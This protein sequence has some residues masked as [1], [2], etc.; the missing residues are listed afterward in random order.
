MNLQLECPIVF[1]DLETTGT[2]V[3]KDRIVELFAKK[4]HPQGQ[5]EEY[6]Q[7]INP[8]M[9]I[10][11]GASKVHGITN[12]K[13]AFEPY[14]ED[15]APAIAEFF[16]G[17]DVGGYNILRF[18]VPILIEEFYRSNLENP[19]ENANFVDSMAIFHKMVPRSLAGALKYYRNKDLV[20]A[21]SAKGDVLA[22]I[23][24]FEAQIQ[25]HDQLPESTEKIEQF[26]LNGKTIIDYAG[27]FVKDQSGDIVF[28]FGKH[29]NKIASQEQSYLQWMLQSDF[30]IQTKRVIQK[31]IDN[32]L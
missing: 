20:N 21:H 24:V 15:V 2:N 6:Y 25:Q 26:T 27:Y 3:S 18:D 13:V 5:E 11:Y 10:P 17:C 14:F 16:S 28:N 9:E 4:I 29:K 19:L 12:E 31:I 7:L 30:P 8:N 32:Q 1:F 23:E 22:T